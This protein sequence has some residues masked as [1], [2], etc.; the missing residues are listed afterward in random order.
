MT[1]KIDQ[2]GEVPKKSISDLVSP[3]FIIYMVTMLVGIGVS[4]GTYQINMSSMRMEQDRITADQKEIREKYLRIDIY[5]IRHKVLEDQLHE[6]SAQV[7]E[8]KDLILK[9]KI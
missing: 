4:I 9:R 8:V 6:I 1:P 2:Q 7:K 5:E 3:N